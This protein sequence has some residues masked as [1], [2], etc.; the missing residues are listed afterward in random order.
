MREF[1]GI[2]PQD[3]AVLLKRLISPSLSQKELSESLEISQA[4]ISHGLKRLKKIKLINSDG[5]TNLEAVLEF[6]V[7]ALKYVCPVELGTLTV[8]VPTAFAKPGFKF[9]KYDKNDIYVWPY[10]NGREKGTAILPIYSTLVR[11][12]LNDDKLYTLVSLIEMIRV[13]RQREQNIAAEEL[14]NLILDQK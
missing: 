12:C 7:H 6:L 1:N 2:R 14:K 8:G 10:A 4:E 5:Q 9:V 13:G 3:I 11:A